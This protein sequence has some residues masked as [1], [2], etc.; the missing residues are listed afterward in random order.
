MYNLYKD[1]MIFLFYKSSINLKLILHVIIPKKILKLISFEN[2]TFL[3][4]Y[5]QKHILDHYYSSP[6]ILYEIHY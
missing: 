6:R 5:D 3:N 2:F 1:L 4:T